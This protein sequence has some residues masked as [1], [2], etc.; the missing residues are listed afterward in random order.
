MAKVRSEDTNLHVGIQ[1]SVVA[2]PIL[3]TTWAAHRPL[4][5]LS[6][7][8]SSPGLPHSSVTLDLSLFGTVPSLHAFC[9]Q[10]PPNLLNP[11]AIAACSGSQL[12]HRHCP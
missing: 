8:Y 11:D 4:I 3:L 7:F 5:C 9:L 10:Q 2:Q 12:G 6:A 1:Q